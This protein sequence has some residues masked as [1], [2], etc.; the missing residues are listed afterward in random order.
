MRLWKSLLNTALVFLPIN[1]FG[2]T[3]TTAPGP[4]Q[5]LSTTKQ[6]TQKGFNRQSL[7]VSD[8][9]ILFISRNRKAHH[10]PQ[11]YFKD[12][13]TGK[14]RQIT[15]QRGVVANGVYLDKSGQILYASSTDEDKESPYILKK[16]LDR[17]PSSVQNDDFFQIQFVPQE[18][19]SS[20]IDGSNIKRLTD[21]P[22]YDGFPIHHPTKDQLY[23]SRWQKGQISLYGKSLRKELAPWKLVTTAGHDLGLQLSPSKEQFLW[24]RFSPDF[25]SSQLL[26]SDLNFK[27]P[28]FLTLNSGVSWS[29]VWHPNGNSVIY[30]ARASNMNDFNLFEVSLDGKCQRQLTSYKGD[31][32]FPSI[33]PNGKKILFTSTQSGQEQIH[34]MEYPTPLTCP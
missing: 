17:F 8:E 9:S 12:L 13:K 24:S 5:T 28:Q 27:N 32:F 16:Y 23:F 22:G 31:E 25:K 19:Y 6:L 29:P 20:H 10:D 30:S 26:L 1:V 18:I 14:E 11:I 15:H 7:F 2:T 4:K 33:S 3:A 34:Q 21:F